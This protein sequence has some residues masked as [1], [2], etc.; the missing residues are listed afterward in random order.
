MI[1]L[2]SIVILIMCLGIRA[3]DSSVERDYM[4]IKMTDSIKGFFLCMVFFSHICGYTDF[5][6]PTLDAPYQLIRR[7]TGQCIVTM[8]LF[9]SGY[10]IMESIKK[11]GQNYIKGLPIQRF[12]RVFLLFDCA[13]IVFLIYRYLTGVHYSSKKIFLTLVGWDSIG[14]SNW[15]IFCILWTYIFTYIT[16]SVYKHEFTKAVIGVFVLSVFYMAILCKMGKDY[17]WYD[18]ILC[19]F[20][21]MLFSLYRSQIELCINNSLASWIFHLFI[22]GV[23]FMI[24]YQYKSNFIIYQLQ[25]FC[26]V[27]TIITF[28]M[29]FVVDSTLL[30]WLGRNLFEL[31]I[32]QRLPMMILKPFILTNESTSIT[33]YIYVLFCFIFTLIIAIVY[34]QTVSKVIKK[35]TIRPIA[36]FPSAGIK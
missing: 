19:Y 8:F 18:T 4:S 10:G 23:G 15:Y 12:L 29:R 25:M 16:F 24:A 26:F 17:W 1:V 28:T 11:K 27:A 36:S 21:G 3:T 9:Y 35:L 7:I 32:L 2:F 34:R 20:I 14:N 5:S 6:H 22:F 33:K 31:Y 13:I 30:Q